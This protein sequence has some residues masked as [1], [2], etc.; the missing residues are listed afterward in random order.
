MEV[1]LSKR[2]KR[3]YDKLEI[4]CNTVVPRGAVREK[5]IFKDESSNVE[6]FECREVILNE[7]RQEMSS[8]LYMMNKED[9]QGYSVVDPQV[10]IDARD[11][12]VKSGGMTVVKHTHDGEE[13]DAFT[14]ELNIIK[15]GLRKKGEELNGEILTED[16]V[17]YDPTYPDDKY[18]DA[19]MS[20]TK[21]EDVNKWEEYKDGKWET[22]IEGMGWSHE[23]AKDG[24]IKKIFGS[25]AKKDFNSSMEE[26][27]NNDIRKVIGVVEREVGN[28]EWSSKTYTADEYKVEIKNIFKQAM[29]HIDTMSF[30]TSFRKEEDNKEVVMD[31]KDI[32]EIAKAVIVALNEV[33]ELEKKED[34]E[35]KKKA[36]N[37]SL[38]AENEKLKKDIAEQKTSLETLTKS[39]DELQKQLGSTDEQ[40]EEEEQD[41]FDTFSMSEDEE[42]PLFL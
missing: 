17:L 22:S 15:R 38:A 39:F 3:I 8:I 28:I 9:S 33:K 10:L 4:K 13:I 26:L 23:V 12:F 21:I 18:I 16:V 34:E 7:E 2:K 27:V 5:A 29:K 40:S 14:C 24:L 6:M 19:L 25:K 32:A 1:T 35:L 37:E 42:E 36:D 20:T 30:S 41:D 11:A 31:K